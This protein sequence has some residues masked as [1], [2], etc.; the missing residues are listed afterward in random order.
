MTQKSTPIPP[1]FKADSATLAFS[2]SK[3]GK[4]SLNYARWDAS[5]IEPKGFLRAPVRYANATP[6]TP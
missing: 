5:K 3:D 2:A 4:L 6:M 1:L